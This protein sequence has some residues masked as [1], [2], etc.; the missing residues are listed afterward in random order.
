M[1]DKP[2]VALTWMAMLLM[3]WSAVRLTLLGGLLVYALVFSWHE[4][5]AKATFYLAMAIFIRREP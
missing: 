4:E 1:T 2:G 5:W 3:V